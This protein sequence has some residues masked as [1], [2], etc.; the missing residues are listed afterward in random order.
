MLPGSPGNTTDTTSSAN[1]NSLKTVNINN[2]TG[3]ASATT[4]VSVGANLDASQTPS[5]GAGT[6]APLD[7]NDQTNGGRSGLAANGLIVPSATNSLTVGDA[8]QITTSDG[9]SSTYTYGGFDIGKSV[10]TPA[11]STSHTLTNPP[12]TYVSNDS[13]S[14]T[15]TVAMTGAQAAGLVNGDTVTLAGNTQNIDNIPAADFNGNFIISN[16]G[17]NSYQITIPTAATTSPVTFTTDGSSSTVIVNA[18][19]GDWVSGEQVTIANVPSGGVGGISQGNLN[20]TYTI[21][22]IDDDHFSI[23]AGGASNAPVTAGGVGATE[24]TNLAGAGTITANTRVFNG[25][26]LN[27]NGVGDKFLGSL[28]SDDFTSSGLTFSITNS[29]GTAT[30]TY[31]SGTPNPALGQFNNMTNLAQAITDASTGL[32]SRVVNN[33][34]YVGSVNANDAVTFTNGSATGVIN[35]GATESGIDWVGEL[36]LTSYGAAAPGVTRFTSLQGL[37]DDINATPGLTSTV[38]SATAQSSLSINTDDPLETITFSDVTGDTGSPLSAL[39][40]LPT[41]NGAA[42]TG[43]PSTGAIGPAYDPTSS[44]KSMASGSITPQ[45]SRPVQVYDSLGTPHNLNIAFI[46]TGTNTWAAEVFS[47]PAS[48]VT[49]TDGQVAFGNITFNGD[50]SLENVSPGLTNPIPV[51]WSDGAASSSITINWGTAGA[52][53]T[54]K[55]D[56]L[57]QFDST[58][59]VNFV[60]QNGVPVGDLTGVAIDQNGFVTAS[61]SNGQ[62]QKL[63]KIPLAEFTDPNALASLSSNV[64]SQ[65]EQSGVVNLSQAGVGG[66]GTI[67]SSS[68]EASNVELADQLTTMII[69]QRSYEANTKVISTAD[70]LLNDLNQ[71][72]Q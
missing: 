42:P 68:L 4:D 52:P 10:T 15:F 48:D 27:A 23:T 19:G 1:L 57:S 28:S 36:G 25:A 71:I 46:K 8:F 39:G 59:N 16:V 3:S 41:L 7:Q 72:L 21:T 34:L 2:L 20:G 43:V 14:T 51:T 45:F 30:F 31:T 50:G 35:N 67:S 12:F 17:A 26:I 55:T 66:A 60:N 37:S 70:Q 32:T 29:S 63:Y 62:T 47:E 49:A 9:L 61:Y 54:G 58:Y 22:R 24:F 5:L 65:T 6:T 69:A 44:T 64:Y 40:I 33:Q 53:G 18:P 38:N 13:T 11:A 56:G